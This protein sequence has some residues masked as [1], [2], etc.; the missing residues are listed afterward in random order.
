MELEK[1]KIGLFSLL[2]VFSATN[3]GAGEWE[4][5]CG[6]SQSEVTHCRHIKGDAVLMGEQGWLNTIVF[7]NGQRRQYFYTGGTVEDLDGLMVREVGGTWFRASGYTDGNNRLYFQL[8]SGNI[9]MWIS[10]YVD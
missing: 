8:P 5:K 7:P 10:A 2:A 3:V 9:F 4:T 6:R 1:C